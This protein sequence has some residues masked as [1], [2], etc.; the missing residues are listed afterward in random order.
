MTERFHATTD[1]VQRGDGTSNTF[2][3][4]E[5]VNSGYWAD[6]NTVTTGGNTLPTRRDLQTGYI[7]F[8]I[9]IAV[10]AVSGATPHALH[11]QHVKA[12]GLVPIS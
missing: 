1:F 2:L 5:N 8:G 9:S 6:I 12:D 11:G 7:G 10:T 4:A 3:I